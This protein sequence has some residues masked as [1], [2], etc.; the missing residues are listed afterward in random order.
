MCDGA[1]RKYTL[2]SAAPVHVVGA[3][4]SALHASPLLQGTTQ[5][6]QP[7]DIESNLCVWEHPIDLHFETVT[8]QRWPQ[9]VLKVCHSLRLRHNAQ[10]TTAVYRGLAPLN[11]S[12]AVEWRGAR[13]Y[14]SARQT[15][16][17][18]SFARMPSARS[19]P[20]PV[21]TPSPVGLGGPWMNAPSNP[22]NSEV[23]SEMHGCCALFTTHCNAL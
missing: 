11:H 20:S 9:F 21:S 5:P 6:S 23:I 17:G 15:S 7:R 3:H 2:L 12:R 1:S 10:H 8:L 16:R 18:T 4:H 22:M 13:R 19:R 14:I